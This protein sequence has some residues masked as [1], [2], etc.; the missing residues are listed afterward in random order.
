MTTLSSTAFPTKAFINGQWVAGEDAKTFVVNNPA[1]GALLADVADCGVK[2]TEA[3]IEAAHAA[4]AQWAGTSAAQRSTILRRWYELMVAEIETLAFI[5]TREN[6]KPLAEAKGEILYGA[7]YLEWFAEEAKRVEGDIMSAPSPDKRILVTKQ[8]VGVCAAITPWNFPSAML[9]RKAAAALAAGCTMVAK[10]AQETPLSALAAAF[11]GAKAG[12]PAGV[13]N[14]VPSSRASL[15][16]KRMCDSPLVQ[17]ITFT[18]STR[19]GKILLAQ[20]ASTVKKT[21]M[22]LGGNAPF[23]VFEDADIEA[24]VKGA[25]ASK[26]RNAGQT[27]VCSNRFFLHRNIADE[28]TRKFAAKAANLKVANGE[29]AGAQ[30]GP[31]INE[32]AME[33]S[34]RLVAEAVAGGAEIVTGGSA[35]NA[36]ALFFKPTILTRVTPQMSVAREEIFAPIA[37][38]MIFDDE[39]EV[40]AKANN[41]P[42][43]LAAYIYTKN[44]GRAF[45]ISEALAFGMVGVN[46]GVVSNP[47]A[48]FGGV[49]QSG[50]GREGSKYGLDDYLEIKYTLM[51]GLNG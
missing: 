2:E 15:L 8:P 47:A 50:M 39:Q 16:G 29:E 22:E 6:G 14:V 3:A 44:L 11:L 23:I 25:M 30:I 33:N 48:P 51:G 24:A 34:K 49:K 17:K 10:P 43:G 20:A 9:L 28:F 37:P 5:L 46:E 26:Y 45:R 41:V 38:L 31:L 7:S 1:T 40:I 42:V 12:I 21:S 35:D 4:Q 27:C 13:L 19:V 36:G 32:A 18:G